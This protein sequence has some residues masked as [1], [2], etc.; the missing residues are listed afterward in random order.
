[1]R[2]RMKLH[3]QNPECAVCHEKMDTI[4]LGF[5]RFDGI[6]SFRKTQSGPPI[7]VTGTFPN[8][9]AFKDVTELKGLLLRHKADFCRCLTE[10]M[11]IFAL[12]RGLEYIDTSLV[13]EI[14]IELA[15]NGY[16]FSTLVKQIVL[17]EKFRKRR[18]E[19]PLT[20]G[21]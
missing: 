9:Q 21:K 12:G 5:E 4:G 7:I 14:S 13:D 3:R 20:A 18:G 16:R 1:M 8:G 17:S 6:G 15:L 2:A 10:K 11:L 19:K